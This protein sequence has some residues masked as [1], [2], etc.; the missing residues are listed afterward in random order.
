MSPSTIASWP[1]LSPELLSVSIKHLRVKSKIERVRQ[2]HDRG[3]YSWS[4]SQCL[5]HEV[6][7]KVHYNY[8]YNV[9][10]L[11]PEWHPSP[12]QGYP[13]LNLSVP[14]YTTPAYR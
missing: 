2:H 3:P 12:L 5:L 4:L 13:A 14:I 1:D 6:T 8:Y 11:I 9:V 7:I 10:L